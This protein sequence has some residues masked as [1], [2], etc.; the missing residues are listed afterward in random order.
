MPGK[1]FK[2]EE[3]LNK[4]FGRRTSSSPVGARR[5][6]C[7]TCRGSRTPRTSAGAGERAAEAAAG[8]CGARQGALPEVSERRAGV[9]V[10]LVRVAAD[11]GMLRNEGC[12]VN[13]K[14]V[15]RIWQ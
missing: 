9:G 14:R 6:R 8:G 13:H 7:A 11:Q 12:N 15:E 1:R 5:R 10:R 2:A 4:S 3:I